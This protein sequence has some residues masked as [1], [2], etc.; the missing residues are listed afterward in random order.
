MAKVSIK[1]E[2]ITAFGGI[3]FVL[4][5]FDR[6]LSSVHKGDCPLCVLFQTNNITPPRSGI[7][8]SM[9]MLDGIGEDICLTLAIFLCILLTA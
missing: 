2:K 3:F 7:F 5:R 9:I 8:A 1:S 6:I 4:D